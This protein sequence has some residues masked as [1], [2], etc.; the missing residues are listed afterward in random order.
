MRMG[1]KRY[2]LQMN[3][4]KNKDC[5]ASPKGEANNNIR[6]KKTYVTLS[7]CLSVCNAP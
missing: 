1:K 4:K 3:L 5:I 6:R 2:I 7:V